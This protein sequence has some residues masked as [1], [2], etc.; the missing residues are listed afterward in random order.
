LPIFVILIIH[1][2]NSQLSDNHEYTVT[3]YS[4]IIRIKSNLYLVSVLNDTCWK[5]LSC[6]LI[7]TQAIWKVDMNMDVKV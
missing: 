1:K 7:F 6:I 4:V 3:L 5:E 2:L